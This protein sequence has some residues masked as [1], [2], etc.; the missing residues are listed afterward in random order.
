M[1]GTFEPETG[2]EQIRYGIVKQ[3][4]SFNLLWAVFHEWIGMAQDIW[5]APCRP[6]LS[7]LM[8]APG[9]TH[10]GTRETSDTIPARWI[11]PRSDVAR[12][13]LECTR[14]GR[15]AWSPYRVHTTTILC[16]PNTKP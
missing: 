5:L 9:C 13:G 6:K 12:V 10:H 15:S 14:Q 8:R 11:A 4:G 1:L 16:T 7:S 3:L 2:E